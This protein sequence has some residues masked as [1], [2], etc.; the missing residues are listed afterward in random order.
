MWMKNIQGWRYDM[1]HNN[2][3]F[4]S[5]EGTE[6]YVNQWMPEEK[7]QVKGIVQI[8]HGMAET[9]DRYA[10][11]ADRLTAN[12][13]IVYANDHRGHGKTAKTLEHVGYLAEKDGFHWLVEDVHKL[14]EIIKKSHP[15]LPLFLFGH[16]MGS[17]IAQRYITQYGNILK[18][19]IL[20]GSNGRQGIILNAALL[21]AKGEIRK[22]GRKARSEKLNSLIFGKYNKAFHPARTEFDWLS[23]D[24]A[25]VD[26]YIND[27]FCGGVFTAGFFYDFFTG[28]KEIEDKN[29]LKYIPKELP[30]YIFSGDKDPVGQ[31]GKGIIKLY[32]TYQK[33]GIHDVAYKLYE[34][35]RHEMLNETNREE[36]M[37]DVIHWLNMKSE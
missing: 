1:L 36:V 24:D 23:R 15:N 7:A 4:R 25:E 33:L 37:Q 6:I 12:G 17:F 16:S 9:S 18:G 10:R 29:K 5:D 34:N 28:L 22:N 35:G 11:F 31:N 14:S 3:T 21:L 26:K 27:P 20:S 2:F 32:N 19:V 8:A 13:Y 30:I